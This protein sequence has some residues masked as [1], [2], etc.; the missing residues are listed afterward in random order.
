MR[1]AF[2][3]TL[4]VLLLS[5]CFA[6]SQSSS[7]ADQAVES[8]HRRGPDGLEGWTLN[9]SVPDRPNEK[10]PMTLVIARK[11]RVIRKFDGS[12]FVWK[13]IFWDRGRSVAYEAGPFHF[14]L[15][16]ILADVKTGKQLANFDCFHGIPDDAPAWLNALENTP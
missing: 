13:W 12:A 15:A 3:I 6:V 5:P 14:G 7:S 9:E 10:F 1:I 2:R 11:G 8:E 4:L 16:C